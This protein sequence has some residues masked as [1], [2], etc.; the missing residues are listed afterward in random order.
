[1]DELSF[2]DYSFFALLL[3]TSIIRVYLTAP[4][5]FFLFFSIY[6]FLSSNAL[7]YS[8]L[9]SPAASCRAF[10]VGKWHCSFGGQSSFSHYA[11]TFL[12][13]VGETMQ[14]ASPGHG[15]AALQRVSGLQAIS[16]G[17]LG[18]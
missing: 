7:V 10:Q 2:L 6:D 15:D 18:E 11:S 3:S 9:R 16:V 8:R 13:L 4:S 1:L 14:S 12:P 5:F 17:F